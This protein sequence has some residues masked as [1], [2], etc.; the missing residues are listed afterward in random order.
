MTKLNASFYMKKYNTVLKKK[1]HKWY[2]LWQKNDA[3]FVDESLLNLR[4]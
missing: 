2:G 4:L 3:R 1:Q